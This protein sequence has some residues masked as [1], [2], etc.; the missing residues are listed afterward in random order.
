MS[1]KKDFYR[2]SLFSYTLGMLLMFYLEEKTTADKKQKNTSGFARWIAFAILIKIMELFLI[3]QLQ[4]WTKYSILLW[5][6]IAAS[7]TA[8]YIRISIT[9]F[10]KGQENYIVAFIKFLQQYPLY[11]IKCS[12]CF[13]SSIYCIHRPKQNKH[14][15]T[16]I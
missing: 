5:Y 9:S 12:V 8:L 16:N 3:L 13:L 4:T 7:S 11:V 10:L 2:L 1:F 6:E 15:R 14:S